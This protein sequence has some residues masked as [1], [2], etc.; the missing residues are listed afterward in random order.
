M[1]Q[2]D[3]CERQIVARGLCDMHYRRMRRHGHLEQTRPKD[4]GARTSHPLYKMWDGMR[5]RCSDPHHKDYVNYGARGINVCERWQDFWAFIA[6]MG[7]RPDGHTLDR[8]DN[9]KGYSP[10]NCRW[11][12]MSEQA[13]NRRNGVITAELAVEIKRRARR[14]DK[15]GDIARAIGL[16]YDHVRNVILGLSWGD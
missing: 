5:R 13:R 3:G 10:D 15:A 1:C 7:P 2:V 4:W 6:D 9:M 11:A 16:G 8:I 14:G 12:N